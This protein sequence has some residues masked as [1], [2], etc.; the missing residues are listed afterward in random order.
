MFGDST[1]TCAVNH[2]VSPQIR[3]E[4]ERHLHELLTVAGEAVIR[5]ALDAVEVSV[6]NM[7]TALH[8]KELQIRRKLRLP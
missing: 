4:M 6:E 8:R 3:T 1:T 2:A 5:L 7:K